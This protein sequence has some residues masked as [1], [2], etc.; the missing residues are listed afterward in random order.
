MQLLH[1][2]ATYYDIW[3]LLDRQN[4]EYEHYLHV[5]AFQRQTATIN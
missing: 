2:N 3:D 1:F 4:E 5:Q